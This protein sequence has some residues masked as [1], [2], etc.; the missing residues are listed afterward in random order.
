MKGLAKDLYNKGMIK[1][2]IKKYMTLSNQRAGTTKANPKMHNKEMSITIIIRSINS[3][4]ERLAEIAEYELEQCVTNLPTY[5][6]DTT[7][8]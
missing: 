1:G 8:F 2:E 6:H 4:T 7:Q 3:P 5:I